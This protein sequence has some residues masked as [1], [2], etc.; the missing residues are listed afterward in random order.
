MSLYATPV[1]AT[2]ITNLQQG[3]LFTTTGTTDVTNQ[4]NSIAAG[5]LTVTS[6]ASA[7]L[8]GVQNTSQM[9]MAV[10]ALETGATQSVAALTNLVN[11]PAIIPSY[12]SF[13]TAQ[14]LNAGL[15]V[16]EDLGL[17]YSGDAN[18]LAT[19]GGSTL[20]AFSTAVST[21]TGISATFI[22]SQTQYF[23]NLYTANGISAAVTN[24]YGV[25]LGLAVGLNVEGVGS[26]ATTVQTQ[27]KNALYDIAQ[28]T[29]SPP[30]SAYVPGAA[31]GRNRFQSRFKGLLAGISTSLA[32]LRPSQLRRATPL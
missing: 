29:E 17:A 1:S 26:Q 9:A 25:V 6:Y 27:V 13:A 3:I 19:Y 16:A 14:G 10:S 4:V 28:A 15:V 8:G 31:L 30:G 5:N 2:D 12:V 21:L 24:A 22:A 7:L 20:S 18:F 23:I 32:P 11:N